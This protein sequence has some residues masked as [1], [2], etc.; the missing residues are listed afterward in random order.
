MSMGQWLTMLVKV[1]GLGVCT[2]PWLT[3]LPQEEVILGMGFSEQ[4]IL[5]GRDDL[6][7]MKE[8]LWQKRKYTVANMLLIT[9]FHQDCKEEKVLQ[10]E[11]VSEGTGDVQAEAETFD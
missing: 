1:L 11:F 9:L 8:K 4:M 5:R 2:S 10:V 6:D 7:L 3:V